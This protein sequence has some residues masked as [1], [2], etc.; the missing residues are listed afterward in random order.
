MVV[1]VGVCCK[2][3]GFVLGVGGCGVVA[4]IG[5]LLKLNTMTRSAATGS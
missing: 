1:V 4:I 3:K 2:T 5:V